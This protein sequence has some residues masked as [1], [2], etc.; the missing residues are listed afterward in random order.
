[1]TLGTVGLLLLV[2]GATYERRRQQTRE[3]VAW[4]VQMS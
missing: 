1:V 4:V 2:V 3:A